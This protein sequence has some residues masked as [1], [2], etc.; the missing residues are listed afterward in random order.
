MYL[1]KA[2]NFQKCPLNDNNCMALSFMDMAQN[3]DSKLNDL[4]LHFIDLYNEYIYTESRVFLCQCEWFTNACECLQK[5][6]CL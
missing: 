4:T 6:E 5:S 3:P 2:G 1:L